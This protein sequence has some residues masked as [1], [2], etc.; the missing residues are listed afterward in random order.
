MNS[1]ILIEADFE[2]LI[3][4]L[5]VVTNPLDAGTVSGGG[6]YP[7]EHTAELTAKATGGWE[8]INWTVNEAEYSKNSTIQF[9]INDNSTVTANFDRSSFK[10]SLSANPPIGGITTGGGYYFQNQIATIEAKPNNGWKF[11]YW[12]MADSIYSYDSSMVINVNDEISL[13]ANFSLLTSSDEINKEEITWYLSDPYPNPFNPSAR[14]NYSVP[15]RSNVSLKVYDI[16]GNEVFTLVDKEQS[17]GKYIVEFNPSAYGLELAS[18]M[19]F[20][21]LQVYPAESGIYLANGGASN[22]VTTKKM[23]LLK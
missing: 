16:L 2:R 17:K 11:D 7:Y 13:V 14:I 4:I 1:N 10:L 3:Y 9:K 21:R 18:G 8:F 12:S 23:I 19:Y 20:Y 22:F 6:Y 5:N 15:N